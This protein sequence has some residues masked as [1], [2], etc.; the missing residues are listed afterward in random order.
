MA[1]GSKPLL[2]RKNDSEDAPNKKVRFNNE[3]VVKHFA[4]DNDDKKY[5]E[6]EDY[7]NYV[8]DDNDEEDEEIEDFEKCML[9]L[10]NKFSLKF[11]NLG[12]NIF[13]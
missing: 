5:K 10:L 2:K 7:N 8:D 1:S 6:E 4:T 3:T 11:L 12:Y 13:K 9:Q